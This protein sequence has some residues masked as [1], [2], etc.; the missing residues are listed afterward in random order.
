MRMYPCVN[1]IVCVACRLEHSVQHLRSDGYACV[2]FF[3]LTALHAPTAHTRL[4]AA[5]GVPPFA[6]PVSMHVS[7]TAT[8]DVASIIANVS[9]D[10][11]QLPSNVGKPTLYA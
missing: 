8:G 9:S 4:V 5:L 2:R 7:A 11:S 6:L 10:A 3:S 1:V